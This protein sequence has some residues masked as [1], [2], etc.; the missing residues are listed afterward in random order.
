METQN[1]TTDTDGHYSVVL[2]SSTANGLPSDLFSAQEERWL[3][4]KV[5]GQ[6]EQARVLLVSVP[7]AMK[8][9]EADKLAGHSASEFVTTDSLQSVVKQQLQEQA[10]VAVGSSAASNGK[11]AKPG[12]NAPV[13]TNLATNFVDVTSNQVVGVQQNGTGVGL[14][15]N[16]VSNSGVVGTANATAVS[17]IVAGVEGVSSL[18]SSYGVYGRATSTSSA[19]PGIGVYGQ[20][21]SPNGFGLSGW[22]AGTGNTI[23]LQGGASSTSGFAINATETATSGNTAGLVAR[24]YSPIGIPA[25]IFNNSSGPVTGALISART[26]S[27]VQFTVDGTGNVKFGGGLATLSIGSPADKNL[28]VGVGAGASNLAGQGTWNTFSGYQSGQSN[29]S[30]NGNT[31][32]GY[33]SG[34]FNTAGV[35]NVFNGYQAGYSNTIGYYNTFS[36]FSAGYSDT[37]GFFNTFSGTYAG[38]SNTTG[39][40][41]TFDGTYAGLNNT[42]GSANTFSG[43]DAGFTNTTGG[44]NVFDGYQ[45]G[46][47]NTTG[48]DNVFNGHQAGYVNTTGDSNTFVGDDTGKSNTTG[49]GN[50]FI[51]ASAGY[52]VVSGKYNIHIGILAGANSDESETIRIGDSFFTNTTYIA[53]IWGSTISSSSPLPVF[54]DSFGHLGTYTSSRRFKEQIRDMG[55]SSSALMKLRPVTFLYKPEYDKGQRTLQYGLIAEEVAEVYPDL[56]AYE[57]DGRPYTVTYQYLAPMLLNEL[58]KQRDVVA[59]QQVQIGELQK[60]MA[61]LES[62]VQQ[63]AQSPR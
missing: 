54:V 34:F 17:G 61:E 42:T 23:G 58:Q 62:L 44:A 20:S 30:G 6:P 7:Y 2:G 35:A 8:A 24:V 21:D 10:T 13:V 59:T 26:N 49:V 28:F 29:T 41:N 3:A 33:Q 5:E 52:G 45:A 25:L 51:G 18:N 12:S 4:V 46:Y 40:E 48:A 60:R 38:Y 15:A 56:V 32:S 55:D 39:S 9:A 31:F 19:H 37:A 11:S 22:A 47:S 50:T 43:N 63:M 14:S 16:A 53:G 1:V 27:G 36:G 57:P